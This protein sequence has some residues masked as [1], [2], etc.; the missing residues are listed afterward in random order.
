MQLA[1]ESE[2]IELDPKNVAMNFPA[3]AGHSR[4]CGPTE[5][6]CT[7]SKYRII[8][9]SDQA[10]PRLGREASHKADPGLIRVFA[11]VRTA[12]Q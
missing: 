8:A 12:R 7:R 10:P 4:L 1:V 3:W 11:L 6:N 9:T 2:E 5:V